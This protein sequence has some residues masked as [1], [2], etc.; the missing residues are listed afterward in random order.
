MPAPKTTS[1]PALYGAR[2][3]SRRRPHG[4]AHG[5]GMGLPRSGC[6]S[7]GLSGFGLV[8]PGRPP[9]GG[10]ASPAPGIRTR[11]SVATKPMRR[12]TKRRRLRSATVKPPTNR[13]THIL[14]VRGYD[15]HTHRRRAGQSMS[16]RRIQRRR[17]KSINGLPPR[18]A[19][20]RMV[21]LPGSDSTDRPPT[22]ATRES[23]GVPA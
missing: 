6:G 5:G 18:S 21:R 2:A 4:E 7:H 11:P 9:G 13:P 14:T 1:D 3:A 22:R 15:G 19:L 17:R 8:S 23:S 20:T 12:V 10:S 16:L